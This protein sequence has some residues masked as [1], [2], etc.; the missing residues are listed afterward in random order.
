[1][2]GH[3]TD[4]ESKAQQRLHHRFCI[5]ESRTY[6]TVRLFLILCEM[7]TVPYSTYIDC[8]S[9]NESKPAELYK[10]MQ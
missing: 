9:T 7:Q 4:F 5:N 3:P 8:K 1:M 2:A 6:S 10:T